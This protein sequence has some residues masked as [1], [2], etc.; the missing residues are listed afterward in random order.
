LI[1]CH[2]SDFSV[3]I[4]NTDFFVVLNSFKGK[5]FISDNPFAHPNSETFA[6]LTNYVNGIEKTGFFLMHL[7]GHFLLP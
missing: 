6:G 1:F 7:D 3:D 2:L 5:L 4:F